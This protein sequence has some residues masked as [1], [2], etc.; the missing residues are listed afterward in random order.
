MAGFLPLSFSSVGSLP[1]ETVLRV[2]LQH[3]SSSQSSRTVPVR[4]SSTGCSSSRAGY[5]SMGPSW[6]HKPC[7]QT[8]S[9]VASSLHGVADPAR[10][11]SLL[12]HGFSMGSHMPLPFGI[13]VLWCGGPPGASV[14]TS[15]SCRGNSALVPAT[16]PP[17]LQH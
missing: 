15:T 10:S 2:H 3:D 11:R 6:H 13:H 7:Q 4:D 5:S 9:N 16:P 17:L 14:W 8:C 1:S 12:Q